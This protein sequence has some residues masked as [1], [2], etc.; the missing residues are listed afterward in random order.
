MQVPQFT[1]DD[2]ENNFADRHLLHGVVA[3]W[4]ND[5]PEATAILS[6]DGNHTVTWS[7]FDRVTTALAQEL[8]RLGFTKGDFLVTVLPMS[9]DHVLLEYGCF[10]IGVIVA[11]LDL[12]SSAA[13]VIR[14]LEILRPRGF[15]GLGVKAPFDFR[16][17]W[18]AVHT[19]C[20]WLQ[21]SI[22]VDSDDAIAGTR[23]F[24]S[25]AE[26]AWRSVN[27]ATA[28][29]A[30]DSAA[31]DE[32]A[33][34]L[35]ADDGALV[36]FTTGSTGSPKPALLSHRNITVQ[37]MCLCGSFFG[38][39]NGA[40]IL[41]NL[42]PSHVGGQTEALM[43]IFFGGGTAV[44]LEVFDASR[45]MRAITQH[46]VEILGQIPAM[47]NLEWRLKDYDH[48][49]I[50]S[51]KFAAYGGNAVSRPFIDQIASM[52]PVIGTGLG[53]TEA[54]GFCTYVQ[55][56]ADDKETILAGLGQDMPI[57]PCTIRQPM[58]TD[59]NAGDELPSGAIGHLCFRGPQTFLG[60]VNDPAA[61]ARTISSNGFLYT[62]DL[63][64]K[65]AA[66]LHLTGRDK[67]VIK[68][69]GYQIFPGDVEA[70]ICSLHEKVA[71]C[72]VVGVAHEV[73]SEA[74]VAVVE[75]KPEAELSRHDLDHLAR[76]LPSYMRPRHW[77]ILEPGQMPLNRIGKPD[78]LR[79]QEMACQE[80]AHLR[81]QGEWDSS[82][83][84]DEKKEGNSSD[85]SDR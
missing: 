4:A 11:P 78:Y 24:A 22:A 3:K 52:S 69:L 48:H 44:L 65:D 72:V 79:A 76:S 58:R 33:F 23:S 55:V 7:E 19:L 63:G 47:F 57:Y 75:K 53:L 77:I 25:I 16:E 70:H 15:A 20:P 27:D 85:E 10:K 80:I 38:G 39:D 42:P 12:R 74:P 36:I 5:K 73:A 1:L 30:A 34:S 9:V 32:I 29:S 28:E 31:L 41:V 82:Y 60:Y 64:Y 71:N 37:N 68:S 6:A 13:E 59:G 45:S 35:T 46:R 61:T 51:L 84:K 17:L 62:G 40:R 83:I 49:D 8:L 21:H 67:W 50:S 43:S 56:S 18:S 81:A 26:P 54:A 2:Y 14:A 66:G